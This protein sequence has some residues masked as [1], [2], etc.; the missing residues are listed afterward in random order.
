MNDAIG[1]LHVFAVRDKRIPKERIA[2]LTNH[3]RRKAGCFPKS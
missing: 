3:E 2:K 1:D